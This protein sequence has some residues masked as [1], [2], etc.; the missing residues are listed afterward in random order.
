MSIYALSNLK[1]WRF[2]FEKSLCGFKLLVNEAF[3]SKQKKTTEDV[4]M[5]VYAPLSY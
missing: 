5:L 3:S 4:F 2:I 1:K